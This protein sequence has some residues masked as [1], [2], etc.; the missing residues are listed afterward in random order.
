MG[1]RKNMINLTELQQPPSCLQPPRLTQ[2]AQENQKYG[3]FSF[4]YL[5]AQLSVGAAMLTAE[6]MEA[7]VRDSRECDVATHY[8]CLGNIWS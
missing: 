5:P 3:H 1:R 2:S 8:A 7:W 4:Q 6:N